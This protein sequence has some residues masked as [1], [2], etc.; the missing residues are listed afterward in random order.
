MPKTINS[1]DDLNNDPINKPAHYNV[2]DINYG[3]DFKVRID[4][5]ES[6]T[7]YSPAL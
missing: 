3:N 1:L 4:S 6:F 2:G 7:T 5:S